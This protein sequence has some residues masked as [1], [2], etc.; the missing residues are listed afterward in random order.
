MRIDRFSLVR[1]TV[2][3]VVPFALAAAVLVGRVAAQDTKKGAA[4]K[5]IETCSVAPGGALVGRPDQTRA[6][7][8]NR[9]MGTNSLNVHFLDGDDPW[10]R[11]VQSKLKE[12]IGEWE[13]Y[14]NISFTFESAMP[15]DIAI[16]F[17]ESP[18]FT[19]GVYQS[20]LG[21]ESR[22]QRPSMWLIFQPDTS[23][24]ELKRVI[25]HEF[26][27]A[28]G[29]IHEQKR[30]DSGIVWNEDAV[31]EYYAFT[32]WKPEEIMDQVMRPFL[33]KPVDE[34]PF[35]PTSIMIYPIP[36]GLAN[37]VVGWTVDLS[38]MDKAFI[39]RLYPFDVATIPEKVIK[40]GVQPVEGKITQKG[41]VARY[42]F[43]V[44]RRARYSIEASG[45]M[46]VL[47]A[48]YG[49]RRSR[50]RRRSPRVRA[51]ARRL[52]PILIPPTLASAP[53]C[54]VRTSSKSDISS[55]GTVRAGSRL[56]LNSSFPDFLY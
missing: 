53:C 19:Y 15:A 16:Q 11:K 10:N 45:E 44:P 18:G 31:Y 48:L 4:D 25:L 6:W 8:A 38:A 12:I 39:G 36:Q 9:W 46:P 41:Q 30:P 49:A 3:A 20:L 52:S 42:R 56:L 32:G 29:L 5:V 35:D 24:G 47:M 14:A 23:D 54:P 37:I 50:P 17:R 34:S 26:G 7:A 21:P 13:M 43:T 28:L 2:G 40:V 33:G 1:S 51:K 27:H 55:P 22:G